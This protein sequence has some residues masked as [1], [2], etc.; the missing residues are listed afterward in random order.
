MFHG[1]INIV[2]LVKTILRKV[3]WENGGGDLTLRQGRPS[4]STLSGLMEEDSII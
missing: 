4:S 3:V 2:I 1:D